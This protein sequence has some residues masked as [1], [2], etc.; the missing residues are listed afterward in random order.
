VAIRTWGAEDARRLHP[1]PPPLPPVPSPSPR[2]PERQRAAEILGYAFGICGEARM[3]YLALT[4]P[5]PGMLVTPEARPGVMEVLR[6]LSTRWIEAQP[7]LYAIT[8]G[9][10]SPKVR[11]HVAAFIRAGGRAI[12]LTATLAGTADLAVGGETHEHLTGQAD[13]EYATVDSEMTAIVAAL[14]RQRL[15]RR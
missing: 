3:A 12:T 8:V 7:A 13:A 10:P 1:A 11:E 9:Y 2:L 6:R 15:S 5:P 4:K 14:H